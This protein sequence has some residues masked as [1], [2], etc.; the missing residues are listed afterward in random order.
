MRRR[1]GVTLASPYQCTHHRHT[2]PAADSPGPGLAC[3][4]RLAAE[5]SD[6]APLSP[7]PWLGAAARMTIADIVVFDLVD[8]HLAAPEFEGA[9]RQRFPALAAHHKRVAAQ[10]GER[11]A[12]LAALTGW[13]PGCLAAWQQTCR[14]CAHM[15][16]T[17]VTIQTLASD[18]TH[19]AHT[20]ASK[21]TWRLT[22][23][24]STCLATSGGPSGSGGSRA[25]AA[26]AACSS[27]ECAT[28]RLLRVELTIEGCTGKGMHAAT[29]NALL[30]WGW[31]EQGVRAGRRFAASPDLHAS[32]C[33]EAV[34]RVARRRPLQSHF[35]R[36]LRG[37]P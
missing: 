29:S 11:L 21:S 35:P 32:S 37:R 28:W 8:S 12:R 36:R 22:T 34:I 31:R 2:H 1:A 14:L 16:H 18:T 23:A 13:P 15:T 26:A 19:T 24:T 17:L 3:L 6:D 20:Q 5:A 10:P 9:L 30:G 25:A 4:E 33:G 27:R 7:P